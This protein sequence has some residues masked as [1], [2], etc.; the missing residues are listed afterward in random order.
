MHMSGIMGFFKMYTRKTFFKAVALTVLLSLFF[1]SCARVDLKSVVSDKPSPTTLSESIPQSTDPV[2]RVGIPYPRLGMWWLN[3]YEASVAEMAQYDLLL[4]EFQETELID[5]LQKVRTENPQ[6]EVFRPLSPSERSLFWEWDGVSFANPEIKNL[7]SSFFLVR[8]GAELT[9]DIDEMDNEIYV[10]RLFDEN[11]APCFSVGGAVAIGES[12]SAKIIA[13]DEE[14]RMLTVERGYV[15]AAASHAAGEIVAQHICFWYGT[16]VM[17]VTSS[18]PQVL[19]P[20]VDSPVDWIEYFYLLTQ[21]Q[22]EG[23]Y[24]VPSDNWNYINQDAVQYDGIIIDR[25]EDLESWLSWNE[26]MDAFSIDLNHNLQQVSMEEFDASWRAG[27]DELLA[28]LQ[29]TYPGLPIIRNNPLSNRYAQY[30]GQVFECG[31]WSDPSLIWWEE[32]FVRTNTEDYYAS[33][34]YL[35]WFRNKENPIVLIEVYDEEGMPD[36]DSDG[37][38]LNPYDQEGFEPD[39][40]RM[41]F[42]L[43]STLLGD[44]YFSYEINTNGHGSLGLMWFDEYD[45]AGAGKGY[46]GYPVRDYELLDNGVYAREY[47][48]G[49]V[50]V[51]PNPESK[52]VVLNQLYG[53]INGTQVPEIN[54]GS[55]V[56]EVVLNGFDGLIL[57]KVDQ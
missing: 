40:Q 46:L 55:I 15:R 35:D 11:G 30:D 27:T 2:N 16:W 6:I 13:I 1:A 28:L 7:P 54:D 20:G 10:D 51:N 45:N 14:K 24:E 43:T 3:T 4:N 32:L 53:K 50:L 47:E 9:E 38:Y 41:R 12:E 21:N 23:I 52:T 36:N 5:K 37:S 26:G 56:S 22:V 18:C 48:Y 17:N 8:V 44:G 19:V 25:F 39:Y 42:A 34:C 57:L 33:S 29:E 31:G 49:L